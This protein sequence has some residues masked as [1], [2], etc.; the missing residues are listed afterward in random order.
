MT[1]EGFNSIKLV[2]KPPKPKK[3]QRIAM[4]DVIK[5]MGRYRGKTK[6]PEMYGSVT[7]YLEHKKKV[8]EQL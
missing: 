7:D 2:Q 4:K 1:N 6:L 3:Q 8:M 5:K